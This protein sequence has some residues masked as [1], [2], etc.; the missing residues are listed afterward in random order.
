MSVDNP[1]YN[2]GENSRFFTIYA[3]AGFGLSTG[4]NLSDVDII[5]SGNLANDL[6]STTAVITGLPIY[7]NIPITF[8]VSG[9]SMCDN[10]QAIDLRSYASPAGGNFQWAGQNSYMFDPAVYIYEGGSYIDYT[11]TNS[12]GCSNYFSSSAPSFFPS[13]QFS[14]S[15]YNSTCGNND[16]EINSDIFGGTAPYNLYWSN[17]ITE[18]VTGS[19]PT[20]L[21]NLYSGNYYGNI[22]DANGCKSVAVAHISDAEI[23]VTE[24]M[25]PES[26]VHQSADAAINLSIT[27]GG[28]P[29]SFLWSNGETTE[30]ISGL[31]KGDYSIAIKTDL[32]C[33]YY[34][35]YS[36]TNLPG[37]AVENANSTPATCATP[38]GVIDYDVTTGSSTYSYLW[39]NGA[40]TEDIMNALPGYYE[41]V[42][43]DIVTGCTITYSHHVDAV[44]G[45]GASINNITNSPC[46]QNLGAV[47][48]NTWQGIA[49]ITSYSWSNGQT[50]AD[51]ENAGPGSYIL[52]ITDA[53]GCVHQTKA[54]IEAIAPE[55]PSICLLT[56]DSSFTYNL[57]VWEKDLS[58][59]N[60]AGYKVYRELSTYGDFELVATRPFALESFFQDNAASPTDRSW[61]YYI[62]TYDAC[63]NE[64]APSDFHKTIHVVSSTTDLVNY[65]LS[66][67][68]YEGI[69]Y[70]SVDLLRHDDVNGW[71]VLDNLPIATTTYAD[72][73][74]VIA[75][76]DYMVEFNL[77]SS[78][79]S[80]KA[81][82]HNSTRSN[83]T[84][85][86]FN[87]GGTTLQI[88]DEEMGMISI[89]PNPTN[90]TFTI[91][92][93][94]PDQVQYYEITDLNGNLIMTGSINTNNT[95]VES[96]EMAAGVYLIKIY[97][98]SNVITQKLIVN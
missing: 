71:V 59:P 44:D 53:N 91:H 24:T 1:V 33:K 12:A 77:T 29:I 43:T 35:T 70:T 58:Q 28:T 76:L 98:D 6:V 26:C 96:S 45:P 14:T 32:G 85:S 23:I 86:V 40:T 80:S 27:G 46:M 30:D 42:V 90:S 89:Y 62:T 72:A 16:G 83:K 97:S 92:V 60:I 64:S 41:C 17:G 65:S 13:P 57:V 7:G 10:A 51:L 84:A 88:Q 5:I 74:P 50:T 82:D 39:N 56:V 48:V 66:W 63:G 47:E 69:N 68:K 61:R 93:D 73:P 36:T 9:L 11:Y 21:Q 55:R 94:Q 49:P 4:L 3:D 87:G 81:Q 34:N 52:T 19:I 31:A 25:T 67:D 15:P 95:Q 2:A 38:N 22:T 18:T 79:T 8:D 37:F 78:C 20:T 75:G 54:V